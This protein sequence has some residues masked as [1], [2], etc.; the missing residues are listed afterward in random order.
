MCLKLLL[1]NMPVAACTQHIKT[2]RFFALNLLS[3]VDSSFLWCCACAASSTSTG[4]MV[5]A[6]AEQT[7]RT[8]LIGRMRSIALLYAFSASLS[9]LLLHTTPGSKGR[10]SV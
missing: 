1:I 7:L 5:G 4:P 8:L 10:S 2:V 6:D 3:S 9:N